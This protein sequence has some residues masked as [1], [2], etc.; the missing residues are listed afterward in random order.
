[1]L[2]MNL[3]LRLIMIRNKKWLSLAALIF[4]VHCTQAQD[5][6]E[7]DRAWL[8]GASMTM[9]IPQGDWTSR[10]T[11]NYSVGAQVHRKTKSNL[12]FSADWGFLFGG[13]VADRSAAL[14]NNFTPDGNLLNI[15]G[16]YGQVNVNQRGTFFYLGLEKTFN[17]FGANANSGIN[18]GLS[19]GYFWH[20]LNVDNVGNDSPQLIDEYRAG[21]DRLGE[22]FSLRESIGYL[23]LSENRKVNAKI[24]FEISQLWS[25]DM[26]KYYYPIGLLNDDVQLNLMYSLKLSWFIPIY[27]GGKTEEYYID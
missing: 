1:M 7:S 25:Q 12:L 2:E 24:S 14:R 26:R 18:I 16:S 22:G 3:F 21:Y 6:K 4:A 8:I 23:Y 11:Q 10:F 19:G 13:E 27:L 5:N 9:N 15:N 20:W 17:R